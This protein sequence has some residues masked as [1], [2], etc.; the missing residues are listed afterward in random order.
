[1]DYEWICASS[2]GSLEIDGDTFDDLLENE[3]I[4]IDVIDVRE[5]DE[6]PAVNE[7]YHRKIPLQQIGESVPD[8]KSDTVVVFCQSG[9]RSKQAAILLSGI[10]G[11]TKKIYSLKGGIESW[12][13]QHQAQQS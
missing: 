4:A 8:I 13:K 10:F 7:F 2:S 3:S 12:K 1:M 5:L 11:E 6:M 9:K